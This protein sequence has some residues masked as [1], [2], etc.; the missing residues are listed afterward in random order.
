MSGSFDSRDRLDISDGR[1]ITAVGK[2]KSGKSVMG[3]LLFLSYPYDKLVIDV[4]GDDGPWGPDVHEISGDAETLP[5]KWP[6]HLRDDKLPMTLRYVP[7]AGSSTFIEDMDA[8]VG[9]AL[10][11]GRRVGHCCVLV[12]EGGVLAQA[13]RTPPHT[14]R[15]LMHNR[16][17]GLTAIFAMPRPQ[18]VD[19]LVVQ[20]SDLVYVFDVPNP[21]DRK[22]LAETIGWDPRDFDAAW[23]DLKVH[24]YLRYDAN[25]PRPDN[26]DADD[27]RLVHFPALPEDV[28]AGVLRQAH[29]GQ[30]S[31]TAR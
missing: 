29:G 10:S 4:A 25:E 18:T 30:L 11:H 23:R 12:H 22:R 28:V 8:A 17:N 27:F 21:H 6:E 31:A 19:P 15:A 3:L 24:E 5:R 16:H 2:K 20:Q 13:N 14:R 9:L 7:D 26:P 1:I